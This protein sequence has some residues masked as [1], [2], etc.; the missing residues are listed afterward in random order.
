MSKWSDLYN[1]LPDEWR[2]VGRPCEMQVRIQHLKAE[3]DRLKRRYNQSLKEID[4]HIANL[5]RELEKQDEFY[6]RVKSKVLK[7]NGPI[8]RETN[9]GRAT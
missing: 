5:E 2:A 4:E 7:S 1:S 3:K 8:A 9:R 6:E